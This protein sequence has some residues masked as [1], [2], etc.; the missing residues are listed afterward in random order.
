MTFDTTGVFLRRTLNRASVA[1]PFYTVPGCPAFVD[2][3]GLAFYEYY[4]ERKL[5]PV[6]DGLEFRTHPLTGRFRYDIGPFAEPASSYV[7]DVTDPL[8]PVLLEGGTRSEVNGEHFLAIADTQSVSHR[9]VVAPDEVIQDDSKVIPASAVSDA[10][11]T[12]LENLRSVTQGADYL[13]I[14]FDGFGAA[15]ESLRV[16]RE[17]RLPLMT[18]SA[19]VAKKVPISALYDQFSGGRTD[20]GAVRN[21]LRAASRWSRNPCT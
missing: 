21:F 10:P 18:G 1:V 8:R 20:P 7:F 13:V 4:Y 9:Y 14:F 3:S 5:M 17:T 6:D 15:A 16:W 11:A 12:S 2:R 19:H